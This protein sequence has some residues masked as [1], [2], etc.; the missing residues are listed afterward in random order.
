MFTIFITIALQSILMI[1]FLC[2]LSRWAYKQY[3]RAKSLE[4]RATG[5]TDGTIIGYVY[6][7]QTDLPNI[8][9]FVNGKE[10][11]K[12]LEYRSI[13]SIKTTSRDK[14][15]ITGDPLTKSITVYNRDVSEKLPIG[16]SLTVFYDPDKP[17]D[18]YVSRYID[19]SGYWLT[20]SILFTVTAIL[21]VIVTVVLSIL[22][23]KTFQ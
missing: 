21:W 3:R 7:K 9:Y 20:L 23:F 16:M 12:N 2:F 18:S 15:G 11:H 22:L 13:I 19:K 1:T 10:Y 8:A 6:H 17:K 5:K 4:T 14:V